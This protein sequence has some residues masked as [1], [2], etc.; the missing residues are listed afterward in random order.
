MNDLQ[1]RLFENESEEL[2]TF[3]L[4]NRWE[5]HS[6]PNPTREEIK[7]GIQNGWYKNDRQTFWVESSGQK[8]GLIIIHD[9]SDTIP[10]FDL[11]LSENYRGRGLGKAC[12]K[13]LTNY[14]FQ[15]SDKKIRIEAYTRADNYPMRKTLWNCG[16]VKEGYMRNAWENK[17]GTISDSVCY[18]II[19]KD[20]EN[21]V[22]TPIRLNEV[23]F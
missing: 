13:W 16:Y 8:M 15:L 10:L 6:D 14:L 19:R 2:I 17:D 21:N 5:F 3:M 12:V 1:F 18:A 7:R 22:S 23:I 11:R 9:F 4:N 20:W